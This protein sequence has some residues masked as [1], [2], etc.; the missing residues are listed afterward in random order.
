[1]ASTVPL[2]VA[3]YDNPS[4]MHWSL[5][6][7]TNNLS[8]KTIIHVL[9]ARQRYFLDVRTPSD[10]RTSASLIAILPLCRI[11][12]SKIQTLNNVVYATP[13]RN[14]LADWSCQ[15]FGLNVLD[16]LEEA[17]II[18]GETGFIPRTRGRLLRNRVVA[19]MVG[20]WQ[21]L[22]TESRQE[23]EE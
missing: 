5:F 9:G 8:D 3:I 11:N 15:D 14:D 19:V 16:K 22:V 2:S 6:I 7:K 20:L 1:M 12:A 18:D 17:L 21:T 10:A 13:I 4:I 23:K